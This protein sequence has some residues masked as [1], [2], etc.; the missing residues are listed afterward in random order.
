MCLLPN[1]KA[2]C[3]DCPFRKDTLRGWLGG[4]RMTEILAADSFVCHKN[5]DLQCAGHMLI[6]GS[7]NAFVR[8]AAA[9]RLPLNLSG[10]EKVFASH[11]DCIDHH[12]KR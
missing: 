6:K 2:P 10:M 4:E 3:R 1:M 9:L 8:L 5:T 7:E 11:G 12:E